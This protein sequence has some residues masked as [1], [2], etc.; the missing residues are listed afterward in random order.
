M[1]KYPDANLGDLVPL[2][3]A[4]RAVLRQAGWWQNF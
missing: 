2:P 3:A 1:I 4:A